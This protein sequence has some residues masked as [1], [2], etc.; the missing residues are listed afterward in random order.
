MTT[1]AIKNADKIAVISSL[2]DSFSHPRS[3]EIP[4]GKL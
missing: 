3:N 1:I 2:F 4:E